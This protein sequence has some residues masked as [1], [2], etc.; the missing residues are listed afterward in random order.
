MERPPAGSPEAGVE[1]GQVPAIDDIPGDAIPPPALVEAEVA[2]GRDLEAF[3]P[4]TPRRAR[5]VRGAWLRPALGFVGIAALLAV[6][7]EGAKWI[8]GDPW[9]VRSILGIPVSIIHDP[10]YRWM[11]VND[12]NLPHAWTIVEAFFETDARGETLLQGLLGAALFTFRGA[13]VGFAL[14]ASVGLLLAILLVHVRFLERA[15]LPL[16]VASQT[17]PIVAIAPVVVVGLKAGWLSIAIVASYLTFFPVT[18]AAIRGMRSADPRAYELMRSYAARDRA[19]LWRLRFPASAPY[20]FTAFKIAA[21]ASV[22]GAIVGE[23]PSGIRDGL[24]GTLLTAMQY[25]SIQPQRLWAAIA[26]AAGL[27]IVCFVLVVLAERWALRHYRPTEPGVA[28]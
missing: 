4:P 11:P 16:L 23:L 15:L 7:W 2:L 10:P 22:V 19:V 21:T 9:D 14:G 27:G 5:R 3:A 17:V 12:I 1:V 28:A 8:A 6:A 24:G 13:A 18:V 26:V 25:Y 20:L